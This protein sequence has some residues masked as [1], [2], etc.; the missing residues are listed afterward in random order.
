MLPWG[1]RYDGVVR[2]L[3]LLVFV[4]ALA[5]G[6]APVAG[7]NAPRGQELRDAGPGVVFERDA[8]PIVDS[9]PFV[10]DAGPVTPVRDAGPV[11]PV[12]DSGPG[13]FDA[14]VPTDAGANDAGEDG[15]T[16]P[17]PDSGVR[18]GGINTPPRDGGPP[19]DGGVECT[20]NADCQGIGPNDYCDPMTF[21]CV[22]CLVDNHCGFNEVCDTTYGNICRDECFNG[23]CRPGL[24]C[25][26]PTDTCVECVTNSDCDN[27]EVCD[28]ARRECV[29]CTTD[30]DCALLP[31]RP[32]CDT[33]DNEC[34]GCRTDADCPMNQECYPYQGNF[35]STPT[36]RAICEPCIADSECGGADDLCIGWSLSGGL[37]DRSC[38]PGC[39]SNAQCPRGWECVNVR[40]NDQVCRPRYDM[41]RPTCTAER[42]LGASCSVDPQDVDP[43][44]GISGL[45]DA[46]CV[47]STSPTVGECTF[48][49][50]NNDDCPT[51]TNCLPLGQTSY[52]F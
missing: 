50:A 8:G 44:C 25:D 46:R 16:P 38:S 4:A 49:C 13:F 18:D 7:L 12:R 26:V 31:N 22:E 45:Q 6:K 2:R 32:F 39:S 35:C 40:Q 30:S 51:G 41:Q 17:T 9:G 47:E 20:S 34:V 29:Q 14:D 48:W 28:P 52:C 1:G 36:N 5:C 43:G 11:T 42:N 10:R 24:I 19:P 33:S 21:T 27:N 23:N 15:G 3:P 37:V